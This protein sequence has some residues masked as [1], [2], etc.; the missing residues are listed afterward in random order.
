MVSSADTIERL[1]EIWLAALGEAGIPVGSTVMRRVFCRDAGVR[2]SRMDRFSRDYPGAFSFIGQPPVDGACFAMWS[3]HVEDADGPSAGEGGGDCFTLR[4]G[5]FRHVWFSEMEGAEADGSYGQAHAV[6]EKQNRWLAEQG[7]TLEDHVIR[8]WWYVRDID[9][10]YR[11]LVEA[12]REVFECHGLTE[13]THF[14]ASTGIAG[15]RHRP[16][17]KLSLDAYAIDGLQPGQIEYISAPEFLGPTH[18]YGV[19]FE[20]ATAVRYGDRS[21]I[22][23]SGTASIDPQG[24]IVHPGD[25]LRQLDRTL[26]NIAALLAAA[27]AELRDLAMIL[28]YVRHPDDGPAVEAALH[29]RFGDLPMVVLHAPVCRP[30]WLVEIEGIACV[31]RGEND[32]PDF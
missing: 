26:E 9:V 8:T 11:G 25:V 7:M 32:F 18:M 19:T 24:D 21:H 4:R 28:V 6:L 15:A 12:R 1:E 29:G 16:E 30:G 13:D 10:E 31:S 27:D 2:K 20:R 3:Y 5:A 14:I 17:A 23:L 22:F